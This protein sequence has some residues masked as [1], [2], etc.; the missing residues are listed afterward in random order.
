[1]SKIETGVDRLVD[2]INKEKNISIDDAAKKL[3]IS[4]VVIQEWADFLEEEKIISVEYKFS[5]AFLVERK[6]SNEEVKVKEKEYSSEKDAFVRK[7]D[8]S[9]KNMENESIGL[10]KIKIE[11]NEIKKN[12]GG[13]IEKVRLE[14]GEL[15][16][17]EYLKKNLDKDIEKQIADFHLLIDRSHKEIDV[18]QKKHQEL[19]GELDVEKREVAVK[20]HRLLT[21]EEKEKELMS[22]IQEIYSL[23]KDVEKRIAAEEIS[24]GASEKKMLALGRSVKEIEEDII[25]RREYIQP[26]LDKAKTHEEEISRLQ[27]EILKKSREK[28][29]SIKN[30]V[31]EGGKALTNFQKFFDKKAIIEGQITQVDSEKKALEDSF[32]QLQK[33]ALAFDFAT[34][35]HTVTTHVKEMEKDMNEINA[36]KNKFKEN[37]EKLIKLIKG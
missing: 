27:D 34:K 3:G 8:T 35:S 30:K 20:E 17:Y 7:V 25:K 24:V 19:L 10:E 28:T 33:K 4:K 26:L 15:E 37:L 13:E 29:E 31:A 5:K 14:V 9:L 18:E 16:K 6:L 11:F 21:L 32:K 23:S 12:I 22:R 36:K 1:M 2:L